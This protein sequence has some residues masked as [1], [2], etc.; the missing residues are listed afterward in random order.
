MKPILLLITMLSI[1]LSLPLCA[2]PSTPN[3]SSRC[4]AFMQQNPDLVCLPLATARS[5]DLR[6]ATLEHD[7]SL[8]KL[9]SRRFGWTAGCGIGAALG[10]NQ[11]WSS[12]AMP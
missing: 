1:G 5:L 7:L 3:I 4:Q 9:A 11:D 12:K 2:E 8:A 6:V 10:V